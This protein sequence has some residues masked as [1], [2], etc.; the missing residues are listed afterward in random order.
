MKHKA[1]PK[2]HKQWQHRQQLTPEG[3]IREYAF[4]ILQIAL[5]DGGVPLNS[6]AKEALWNSFEKSWDALVHRLDVE[7]QLA[8]ADAAHHS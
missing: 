1:T 5:D 2:A 3:V 8:F 4:L 6:K 7:L